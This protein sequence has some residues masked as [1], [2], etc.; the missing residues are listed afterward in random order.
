MSLGEPFVVTLSDS[1]IFI[2][3]TISSGA[4]AEH[5]RKTGRRVTEETLGNII[6]LH[7]AEV[8]A[9][10][11][12]PRASRITLF[13]KKFQVVGSDKS[14]QFGNP[15][16]FHATSEFSQLLETLSAARAANIA[17]SHVQGVVEQ[18]NETS[19]A[20][21]RSGSLPPPENTCYESQQLFS[22]VPTRSE[23]RNLAVESVERPSIGLPL[24]L[25][26]GKTREQSGNCNST[27]QTATLMK[28]LKAKETGKTTSKDGSELPEPLT[29]P[30][31]P[32]EDGS[33]VQ[34]ITSPIAEVTRVVQ[35]QSE[36]SPLTSPGRSS[37]SEHQKASLGKSRA[38]NIRS[39]DTNISNEQRRLLDQ[40]DSWLP[41]EPGRRGPVA[42]VPIAVLQEITQKVEQRAAGKP[43]KEASK[44]IEQSLKQAEEPIIEDELERKQESG[45]ESPCPSADW[46]PSSPVPA[47]RELPPDSSMEM[48]ASSDDE[49]KTHTL[50]LTTSPLGR[51]ATRSGAVSSSSRRESAAFLVQSDNRR[52]Q[53]P[54]S[55]PSQTDTGHAKDDT[56]PASPALDNRTV[57]NVSATQLDPSSKVESMA[58]V[59]QDA[60]ES[61]SDIEM[62]VPLKLCDKDTSA[63]DLDFRQEVPATAFE[64]QEPFTQV[65]RT[66]YGNGWEHPTLTRVEQQSSAPEVFSS[67]SKRR[68][69]DDLGTVQRIGF[70]GSY[71]N[72]QA[73][74]P[75]P[76]HRQGSPTFP[77]SPTHVPISGI[78]ETILGQTVQRA[79]VQQDNPSKSEASLAS[80]PVSNQVWM[81]EPITNMM[82]Q[83]DD[84]PSGMHDDLR[85]KAESPILSPYV[86]KRRKVHKSPFAFKFTQEEHLKEDPSITA[87]RYR[88][89]YFASRKNPRSMSHMA[90]HEVGPEKPSSPVEPSLQ[91]LTTSKGAGISS[92][93]PDNAQEVLHKQRGQSGT[94]LSH[95]INN[96]SSVRQDLRKYEDTVSRADERLDEPLC[97]TSTFRVVDATAPFSATNSVDKTATQ[98]PI[99]ANVEQSNLLLTQSIQPDLHSVS[100]KL[101]GLSSTEISQQTNHSGQAQS[102]PELMTPALSVS[103]IAPHISSSLKDAITSQEKPS[104]PDIFRR[105]KAAYPDYIGTKEHFTGMCKRIYQLLNADRM[106]HKS[107]WDDFIVRHK[108]DYQQYCQRRMDNAEDVKPYER[109]Y[110]EEIDEPKYS[111]R[112]MQPNTLGE[113]IPLDQAPLSAQGSGPTTNTVKSESPK[114]QIGAQPTLSSGCQD[115]SGPTKST[116]RASFNQAA[117]TPSR[118]SVTDA[119]QSGK[120][121][122]R[123]Q[124][125]GS[126]EQRPTLNCIHFPDVKETVDLTGDQSSSPTTEPHSPELGLSPRRLAKRSPR[127]IPWKEY[128]PVSKE[129]RSDDC[130]RDEHQHGKFNGRILHAELSSGSPNPVK[131]S[132]GNLAMSRNNIGDSNKRSKASRPKRQ[133]AEPPQGSLREGVRRVGS[134]AS[135]PYAV[136][137]QKSLV[138][139][140][141]GKSRAEH[142][143]AA[144][145]EWWKDENTPFREY[146]RLY[147]SITPGR[148]NAWAKEKDENKARAKEQEKGK[149]KESNQRGGSPELGLMDVTNWRL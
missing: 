18:S 26:V 55:S 110:R 113:V 137:N 73:I 124:A 42:N 16:P 134:E 35:S 5:Q 28:M 40:E 114:T 147:Q 103:E 4:A 96:N 104:E 116:A 117:S 111:K 109:F 3:A 50:R 24:P 105:F 118:L 72:V 48:A 44:A 67:P 87:R 91:E 53:G 93:A 57:T 23:L 136:G 144:V 60:S 43:A 56:K 30:T 122:R 119:N 138:S 61:E 51:S 1:V 92:K 148:G 141:G 126:P 106:E 8:V 139:P 10:H 46:P 85:R 45:S 2:K 89:E 130:A 149:Q 69:I 140:S 129:G 38:M 132:D 135:K 102:L 41:A 74:S 83:I 27:N 98:S 34:Q 15:R 76:N 95:Q 94:L 82:P 11:L 63:A 127:K 99:A 32:R 142:S 125:S 123:A 12:G 37:K 146:T 20:S 107:L 86:S 22:Q 13:V 19:P 120:R 52:P 59:N 62:G 39:R 79:A 47:R 78:E 29:K 75:K 145:D 84:Q 80:S 66:P 54:V 17:N 77:R 31:A 58:A 115:R 70:S 131:S 88:E 100:T 9:T 112:I 108:V 143:A 36:R 6:Q 121:L 81:T 71:N 133:D 33:S 68:R 64:P 25:N 49:N 7:N 65:E 14:G 128:E 97:G 101:E 21:P 90:S